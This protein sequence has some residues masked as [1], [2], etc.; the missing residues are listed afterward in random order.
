MADIDVETTIDKA[1]ELIRNQCY[2]DAHNLLMD[3]IHKHN[4]E[5]RKHAML[6]LIQMLLS[7]HHLHN[8]EDTMHDHN[9]HFTMTQRRMDYT[10]ALTHLQQ[11]SWS[12][13][14][15]H[16]ILEIVEPCIYTH[17]AS[18]HYIQ[19]FAASRYLSRFCI[20]HGELAYARHLFEEA[21]TWMCSNALAF[22][23]KQWEVELHRAERIG[24]GVTLPTTRTKTHHE[25]DPMDPVDSAEPDDSVT[26]SSPSTNA[27]HS[28]PLKPTTLHDML[29]LF[30]ATLQAQVHLLDRIEH[31]LRQST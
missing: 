2:Q 6:R 29:D 12:A 7:L 21:N 17:V 18:K 8:N 22:A 19:A 27:R 3:A 13:D 16:D 20:Q 9:R 5:K 15:Y 23:K 28:D 24:L 31:V 14:H 1:A 10:I 4:T 26:L 11:Y 25:N 30:R